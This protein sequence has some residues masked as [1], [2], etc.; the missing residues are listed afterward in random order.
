MVDIVRMDKQ[1]RILIPAN[2]RR[3][4]KSNIFIVEVVEEEIHLKPIET[5]N[6]T[7]FIDK[8]EVD[9][10]DFTDTHKLRKA[11]TER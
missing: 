3:N 4:I 8:I 2:I 7:S 5:T 10:D 1:G 11:L 9:V 6:L